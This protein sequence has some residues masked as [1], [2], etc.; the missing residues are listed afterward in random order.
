MPRPRVS[1]EQ[2][3]FDS[4]ATIT[5]RN[6]GREAQI[7]L[8][9]RLIAHYPWNNNVSTALNIR[10]LLRTTDLHEQAVDILSPCGLYQPLGPGVSRKESA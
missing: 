5:T 10:F 8:L 3:N 9:G 2:T 4:E 6:D 1:A 7:L